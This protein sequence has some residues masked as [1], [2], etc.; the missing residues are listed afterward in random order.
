M[1]ANGSDALVVETHLML[2]DRATL[3][4]REAGAWLAGAGGNLLGVAVSARGIAR[5]VLGEPP[6]VAELFEFLGLDLRFVVAAIGAAIAA[7]RPMRFRI[8]PPDEDLV[9]D[10]RTAD[11]REILR[12]VRA[13]EA[14]GLK[15]LIRGNLERA[16]AERERLAVHAV[17]ERAARGEVTR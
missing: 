1:K 13:I 16:L 3:T 14:S 6:E 7:D 8:E 12:M 5:Q 11:L 17:A 10:K 15:T 2:P 9:F 4:P